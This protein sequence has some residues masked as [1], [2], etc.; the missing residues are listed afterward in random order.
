MDE[1]KNRL[2]IIEGPATI[3]QDGLMRQARGQSKS[4]RYWYGDWYVN[5]GDER[6]R[7]WVDARKYGFVA[8]G[9]GEWYSRTL[10]NVPLGA[11]VW[12]YIPRRGYVGVGHVIGEP[13]PLKEVVVKVGGQAKKLVELPLEASYK[14]QP[15]PGED[16]TEWVLPIGW[17]R[18]LPRSDAIRAKGMFANRNSAC[19]LR[20]E[21]TLALLVKAFGV[22]A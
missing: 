22:K 15:R 16:I 19:P 7:S 8:A 10:R 3:M 17:E 2:R 21:F 13:R 6:S 11:R 5:F 4:G 18:T 12:V 9:G 14:N 20:D 1:L